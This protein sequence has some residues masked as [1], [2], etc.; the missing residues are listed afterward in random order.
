MWE[1]L[2]PL[3][4]VAAICLIIKPSMEFKPSLVLHLL[5]ALPFIAL[6]SRFMVYDDSMLLVLLYGGESLP[7]KYRIASTWAARE[8]P[9]LLWAAWLSL[10]AWIWRKPMVDENDE[11]HQTRLRL[12]HGTSL[13]LLIL[14]WMLEPFA[15]S[16]EG[17]F[18]A[19]LNP[20]LQTD[21]MVIHPPLIFLAYSLC[22]MLGAI[23]ISSLAHN[24]KGIE[25]RSLAVG[26]PAFVISTLGIGLG[27]LWAYTVLD[28]GGY[29]AWDPVETG[30]MLPWL[31][32]IIL[33]HLRTR[34]GKVEDG[35]WALA[36]IVTALMAF[37][38][39]MVTRAG[40]VW[41]SSIHTFVID[42]TGTPPESVWGRLMLLRSDEVAGVEIMSYLLVMMMSAS[43]WIG[44]RLTEKIRLRS[45]I[46][47]P[48]IALFGM[49]FGADILDGLPG[50]FIALI[51]V[52]P[53]IDVVASNR[54]PVQKIAIPVVIGSLI[55]TMLHGDEFIAF[56]AL[57]IAISMLNFEGWSLSLAG[58]VLYLSASWA[59]IIEILPAAIGIVSMLIPFMLDSE[60]GDSSIDLKEKK[61]QQKAALWAP[62]ILVSC[63]L[64][65]TWTILVA[66]IDSVQ[67][68]VHELYGAPLV[69]LIIISLLVYHLREI[70]ESERI[71]YL[72]SFL[73]VIIPIL[74]FLLADELPGDS[75]DELSSMVERGHVAM[76]ILP[77][78]AVSIFPAGR[79]V[80]MRFSRWRTNF[81]SS[82]KRIPFAA[83]LVH[84]GLLLLIA[85]HIFS[86]TLID[87][88]SAEHRVTLIEDEP[89]IHGDYAYTLGDV[90]IISKGSEEFEQRFDVGDGYVGVE[91]II[92]EVED[93]KVGDEVTKLEPGVLR[94][95]G[96]GRSEVSIHSGLHGDLILILDTTQANSLMQNQDQVVKVRITAFDLPASHLVW[97]GWV[98]MLLGGLMTISIPRRQTQ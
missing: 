62:V 78:L 74:V 8:G 5:I 53:L 16:K 59:A 61:V 10:V 68:T 43:V 35:W 70:V 79:E 15:R 85:G 91:V 38:A 27:G 84:L 41:A 90:V 25:S 37:M 6:L 81:S 66:S 21:L 45:M 26:R 98:L 49:L 86:T 36:G 9:I 46:I 95:G 13:V 64:I 3:A 47:L 22:V 31:G 65:M 94:F 48:V 1:M 58:V 55:S 30:S 42:G 63:Y 73:L 57:S 87:R 93:G 56:I 4:A 83:H 7:F 28:W 89:V 24:C 51:G 19:G 67:F 34:P 44:W 33:L 23:G 72:V 29:W 75:D 14:G 11:T 92:N 97:L 18:G 69:L 12:V 76:F 17:T 50:L 96:T 54:Q 82:G 71:L 20:L 32:L 2:P 52:L 39:T 40:G 88:G 77:A 60:E 80:W